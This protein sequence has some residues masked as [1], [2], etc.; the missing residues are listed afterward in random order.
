MFQSKCIQLS[1]AVF[2]FAS[3]LISG[4]IALSDMPDKSADGTSQD[5]QTMSSGKSVDFNA[6]IDAGCFSDG[7]NLDCSDLGL[8]QRFGC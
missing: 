3:L 1:L 4:S 5:Y 8:D 2:I 6:S 7:Y